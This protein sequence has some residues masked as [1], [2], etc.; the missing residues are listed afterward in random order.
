MEKLSSYGIRGVNNMWYKSFLSNRRQYIEIKHSDFY[1]NNVSKI[2]SSCKE[3]KLGVPQGSVLGPLLFL[4]YVNDLPLSISDANLI[5]YADDISMLIIENDVHDLQRKTEKVISDLEWWVNKNNLI[6]NVKKPGIMSFHNRK[7]KVPIKPRVTLNGSSLEYV[8]D[9]KFLGIY[10]TET[11]NWNIHLQSL[12]H[13]LS[14]VSFMIKTLKETLSPCMIRHIYFTK[15]QAILRSGILLWGGIKGDS[16]IR[17]FKI[18]KRVV[19]LLAGVS[20]RTSCRQL[21]KKLNI[22]TMASLYILEVTCFIQ[23]NCKFLEQNSQVHQ[24]DTRR[25]LDIHVKMKSMETY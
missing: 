5:M 18:Q 10:I 23:K 24:H 8:A 16:S 13:K 2:I 17:V 14:K 20:F 9:L 21:F 12:A 25:K 4:L 15:F 19:R 6:I 11:L 1:N 7:G 22:L 3:L